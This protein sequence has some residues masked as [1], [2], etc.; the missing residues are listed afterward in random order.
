MRPLRFFESEFTALGNALRPPRTTLSDGSVIRGP[1]T[2]VCTVRTRAHRRAAFSSHSERLV[3]L[4]LRR[5]KGNLDRRLTV[6]TADVEKIMSF[7]LADVEE[8]VKALPS[9]PPPANKDKE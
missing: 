3:K 4:L 8:A 1:E 7:S 6:D 2:P 9:P 5:A